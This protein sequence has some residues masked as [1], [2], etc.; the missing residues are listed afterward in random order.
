MDAPVPPKRSKG[1]P[2]PLK[3][4]SY[5][6]TVHQPPSPAS[7]MVPPSPR[8]KAPLQLPDN[9]QPQQWPQQTPSPRIMHSQQQQPQWPQQPPSPNVLD[10]EQP[11][12]PR[13]PPSPRM[14]QREPQWP[15]Q[16]PSPNILNVEQ[17]QWPQRPPSPRMQPQQPQWTQEQAQI[18]ESIKNQRPKTPQQPLQPHQPQKQPLQPQQRRGS[19][20]ASNDPLLGAD[21]YEEIIEARGRCSRGS[22]VI[23]GGLGGPRSV[24]G[25]MTNLFQPGTTMAM[26]EENRNRSNQ[27]SMN[28]LNKIPVNTGSSLNLPDLTGKTPSKTPEKRTPDFKANLTAPIPVKIPSPQPVTTVKK[29]VFTATQIQPSI[30][31][32]RPETVEAFK[33]HEINVKTS[34][35][36][37]LLITLAY[38]V[39]FITILLLS[40]ITPNGRLYIHFTAFW[41]LI[42]YFVVDDHDHKSTDVLETVM[43]NFVKV[44]K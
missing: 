7:K 40:N 21:R 14:Q 34:Y 39:V 3:M 12:W 9:S 30:T 42:L 18:L 10:L 32:I 20:T 24:Q 35:P 28:T 38:S 8:R 16:P 11:Q 19:K 29:P 41:S 23:S 6:P 17:P 36:D 33:K 43:E 2:S 5:D 13:Q 31:P 4:P 26:R 25:S 37:W 15:Q 27:G 1:T 22:S 44:K